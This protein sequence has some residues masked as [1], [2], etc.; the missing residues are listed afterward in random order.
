M[1]RQYDRIAIDGRAM[2]TNLPTVF[3]T[4][5]NA[6]THSQF[7]E[8]ANG[9]RARQPNGN[10]KV[11]VADAFKNT[12]KPFFAVALKDRTLKMNVKGADGQM[13]NIAITIPHFDITD[14]D[15]LLC[16]FNGSHR[17]FYEWLHLQFETAL[18]KHLK[19]YVK[20]GRDHERVGSSRSPFVDTAHGWIRNVVGGGERK[21][22][23][24]PMN[25]ISD[26]SF[27]CAGFTEIVD[28]RRFG[29]K[30]ERHST[31][32]PPTPVVD[33]PVA[34]IVEDTTIAVAD[35]DATD[36]DVNDDDAIDEAEEN[37]PAAGMSLD[38][39]I[40]FISDTALAD[41][42]Q[43]SAEHAETI[44]RLSRTHFASP[45]DT[46]LLD[47]L[48]RGQQHRDDDVQ[49]DDLA[50]AWEEQAFSLNRLFA[51]RGRDFPGECWATNQF[52]PSD[53]SRL[54]LARFRNLSKHF[55]GRLL[56]PSAIRE[57]LCETDEGLRDL[58]TAGMCAIPTNG[59]V[60]GLRHWI[61]DERQLRRVVA[62]QRVRDA[63]DVPTTLLE[64]I[65]FQVDHLFPNQYFGRRGILLSCDALINY[66]LVPRW[67][68][69]NRQFVDGYCSAKLAYVGMI[70][71]LMVRTYAIAFANG[72][73]ERV[74]SLFAELFAAPEFCQRDELCKKLVRAIGDPVSKSLQNQLSNAIARF[75]ANEQVVTAR[76]Q[77]RIDALYSRKRRI[78]EA[79]ACDAASEDDGSDA[80]SDASGGDGRV[81]FL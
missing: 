4:S 73:A 58:R 63:A 39:A 38:G 8:W 34:A 7:I 26:Y 21:I 19:H 55:G 15:G 9:R 65:A 33:D 25:S 79:N 53:T 45:E 2:P 77:R 17:S 42:G 61:V 27:Y 28:G 43:F 1:P 50:N 41:P 64:R 36:D 80:R 81:E 29:W 54:H 66:A 23:T 40:R 35:D 60:H 59:R 30:D 11:E 22:G 24:G 62:R 67:L 37:V 48:E 3:A 14:H 5:P 71:H 57:F 70:G 68:N 46:Q 6:H 56:K 75:Q 18:S 51:E 16:N 74:R 78:D 76:G 20:I 31:A 10:G 69:L 44:R 49:P 12:A 32:Q 52:A 13:Y 47:D 72:K